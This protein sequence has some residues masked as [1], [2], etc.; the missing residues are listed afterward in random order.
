MGGKRFPL[1]IY[2]VFGLAVIGL[3]SSLIKNPGRFLTSILIMVA[4]GFVLFLIFT[5][6]LNRRNYGTSDEMKKYRKAAKR[7]NLKYNKQK[8]K[9]PKIKQV[10]SSK[11]RRKRRHATHLTVIDGKKTTTNKNNNDRASN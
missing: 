6:L 7:S 11:R 9:N 10:A 2:V 4:I 5:S 3:M 8:P 1:F